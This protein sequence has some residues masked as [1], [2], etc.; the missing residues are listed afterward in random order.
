MA[1]VVKDGIVL[2]GVADFNDK[3]E[4]PAQDGGFQLAF[5]V[6]YS[7]WQSTGR[8]SCRCTRSSSHCPRSA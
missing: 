4:P 7:I 8:R 6:I 3:K 2:Y 1:T 5:W